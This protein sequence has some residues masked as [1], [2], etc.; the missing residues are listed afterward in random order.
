MA[1]IAS[2][3]AVQ[4]TT[5]GVMTITIIEAGVVTST[6]DLPNDSHQRFDMFY[7]I[8]GDFLQKYT[9]YQYTRSVISQTQYEYSIDISDTPP[10]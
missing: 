8:F 7:S 2:I 3:A 1:T 5:N 6:T 9:S 10:F 4:S